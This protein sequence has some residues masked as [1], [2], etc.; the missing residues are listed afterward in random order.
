MTDPSTEPA[1]S[2]LAPA[3]ARR[4]AAAPPAGAADCLAFGHAA[5]TDRLRQ[6]PSTRGAR[7]SGA[8]LPTRSFLRSHAA[9]YDC[10]DGVHRAR[11]V[12]GRLGHCAI[13]RVERRRRQRA[14]LV[15]TIDSGPAHLA[16]AL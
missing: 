10:A 6:G 7:R 14:D 13:S 1:D 5:T 12:A 2:R 8:R 4:R 9:P 11:L 15:V 16:G 3:C